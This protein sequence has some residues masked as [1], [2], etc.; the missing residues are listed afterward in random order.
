MQDEDI[1][2]MSQITLQVLLCWNRPG[3]SYGSAIE[4]IQ[5]EDMGAPS[6]LMDERGVSV[7]MSG[8]ARLMVP[9]L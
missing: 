6:R 5:G 1:D 2:G 7:R 9:G 8:G 4:I 3:R